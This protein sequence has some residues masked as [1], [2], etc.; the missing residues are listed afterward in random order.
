MKWFQLKNFVFAEA[1]RTEGARLQKEIDELEPFQ[2]PFVRVEYRCLQTMNDGKVKVILSDVGN[3][4]RC[5]CWV[6]GATPSEMSKPK[7]ERHNFTA[8]E[9]SL[10]RGGGPLHT[11]LRAFDWICKHAFHRDFKSWSCRCVL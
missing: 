2:T 10:L 9:E 8:N 1:V 5:N 7:G 4:A 11:K 6:C 3:N